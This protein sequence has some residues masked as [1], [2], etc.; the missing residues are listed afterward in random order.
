MRKIT[1][2]LVTAFVFLLSCFGIAQSK[3]V[4]IKPDVHHKKKQ[5][6]HKDF[7]FD[8]TNLKVN[9]LD[10]DKKMQNPDK[11]KLEDLSRSADAKK[12]SDKLTNLDKNLKMEDLGEQKIAR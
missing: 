6:S 1:S 9:N 11:T 4:E 2:V 7:Q 8:K 12:R 10:K 3:D 5:V